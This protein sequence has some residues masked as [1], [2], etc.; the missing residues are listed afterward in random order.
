MTADLV[1]L[2]RATNEFY[3]AVGARVQ[4][5][6]K[7]KGLVQADLANAV[8]LNRSS[9]ANIE[10]GRQH[11]PLHCFVMLAQ[12]LDVPLLDLMPDAPMPIDPVAGAVRES[13]VLKQVEELRAEARRH[14]DRLD[15][16]LGALLK[17][18]E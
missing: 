15:D 11:S 17:V 13:G 6:R 12:I 14:A 16:C 10:A 8:G 3:T 5:H 4:A 2:V 9:M 1:A 18:A 7:A